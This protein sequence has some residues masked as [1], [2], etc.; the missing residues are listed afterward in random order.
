M[1]KVFVCI[2]T[3]DGRPSFDVLRAVHAACTR[4]PGSSLGH[5]T[6]AHNVAVTRNMAVA[7]ARGGGHTHLMFVDNDTIIPPHAVESLLA[8]DAVVATGCTPTTLRGVQPTKV[9]LNIASDSRNGNPVWLEHWFEGVM[10]T[11]FC[12]ASCLLIRMDVFDAVGF[13]WFRFKE[14]YIPN[15]NRY[16]MRGED[17]EFCDRLETRG[18]KIIA[19]GNVR[20]GHRREVDI[21]DFIGDKECTEMGSLDFAEAK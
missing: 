4:V 12:G 19:D 15:G 2:T 8:L 13:P 11:P 16:E 7:S 9:R 14:T 17:I 21:A 5:M 6:C 20:C 18:I 10:E 3:R 1:S